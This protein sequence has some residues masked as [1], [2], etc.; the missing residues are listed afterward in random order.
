ML[1]EQNNFRELVNLVNLGLEEDISNWF[2]SNNINKNIKT[3]DELTLKILN[4]P[5]FFS[6]NSNSFLKS[7]IENET[8]R[9]ELSVLDNLSLKNK[10]IL[11]SSM[12]INNIDY[13]HFSLIKN[14]KKNIE[15]LKDSDKVNRLITKLFHEEKF[16]DI[17]KITKKFGFEFLEQSSKIVSFHYKDKSSHGCFYLEIKEPLF[18]PKFEIAINFT[19]SKKKFLDKSK[20]SLP[21]IKE[22]EQLKELMFNNII[23]DPLKQNR[24]DLIEKIN[25]SFSLYV[26]YKNYYN[27]NES[28][29]NK[30]N[31]KRL[32][33]KI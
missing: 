14:T 7:F 16:S 19:E 22:I 29:L 9:R 10:L 2:K 30:H 25:E 8:T 5:Y 6:F 15:I 26:K 3:E 21:T 32:L 23:N 17:E 27:I 18:S 24:L 28:L 11:M 4:T 13:R 31:N 1:I 33:N 20:L 12:L